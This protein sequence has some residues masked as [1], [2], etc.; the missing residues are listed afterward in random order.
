M[1]RLNF[2]L[3]VRSRPDLGIDALNNL[4]ELTNVKPQAY[5]PSPIAGQITVITT[6][7]QTTCRLQSTSHISI[8]LKAGQL[9]AKRSNE[10]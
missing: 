4:P 8:K 7:S 10:H 3:H 5:E 6:L 9:R 2:R 1:D